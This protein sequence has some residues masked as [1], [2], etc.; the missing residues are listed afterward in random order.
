MKYYEKE[1]KDRGTPLYPLEICRKLKEEIEYFI[2]HHWHEELEIIIVSS[3]SLSISINGT[4][5]DGRS[6][7]IFIINR[8]E[9]HE[10]HTSAP[11]TEYYA[12]IIPLEFLSFLNNDYCQINYLEPLISERISFVNH[13][14]V[15]NP[16]HSKIRSE[17]YGLIE[18]N[19]RQP[20][21][22][23]LFTKAASYKIIAALYE[24]GM[25]TENK[26]GLKDSALIKDIISYIEEN[27]ASRLSLNCISERYHLSPK[28]FCRYFK[29]CF[30][31][32]FVSY[33]NYIR[34]GHAR[35]MLLTTDEKILDIA[36]ECGFENFSYFIRKFK[37]LNGLSPANYRSCMR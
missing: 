16:A 15:S 28:Y 30:G 26:N 18:A 6:E 9:I 23:R 2:P 31:K 10:I 34:I 22:Y 14:D 29:N 21:A 13:I 3:G 32:S 27:Y 17:L 37:E 8:S 12:F 5:Y 33:L 7:D 20:E 1:I 36:L 11:E 4:G 25:I 35:T 19:S 24:E